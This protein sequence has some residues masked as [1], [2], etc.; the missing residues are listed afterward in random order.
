MM[1]NLKS[2]LMT[3]PLVT[4][5]YCLLLPSAG[6]SCFWRAT[7][8]PTLLARIPSLLKSSGTRLVSNAARP[9]CDYTSDYSGFHSIVM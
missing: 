6:K 4:A 3:Q 8:S 5:W 1:M 2:S 7:T 9:A